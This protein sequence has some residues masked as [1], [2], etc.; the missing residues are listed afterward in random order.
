MAN[1]KVP[2]EKIPW[3]PTVNYDA[4]IHDQE[5]IDFC[6]NDVFRWNDALGVPEVVKPYNC[7][8]GCDACQ[9]IC[10]SQAISF[11]SHDELR[12]VMRRLISEA[13]REVEKPPS[14]ETAAGIR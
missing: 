8:L 4:C 3:F 14:A 9:Q 6:K 1:P 2:R 5:C 10:P 13:Y 11:P 7:V 12:A